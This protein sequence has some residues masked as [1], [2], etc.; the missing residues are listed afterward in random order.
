MAS[1]N[2]LIWIWT[3]LAVV[4]LLVLLRMPAPYG[5]LK[6]GKW[7]PEINNN[8]SWFLMEGAALIFFL[9]AFFQSLS[10]APLLEAAAKSTTQGSAD[11]DAVWLVLTNAIQ[12]KSLWDF[13]LPN[14]D[15]QLLDWIKNG[16]VALL[17]AVLYV[18]HYTYRT[19]IFPLRIRTK[20]KRVPVMITILGAQFNF[21][22]G[23]LNGFFLGASSAGA[24]TAIGAS[25]FPT[26]TNESASFSLASQ[27]P[28]EQ[29]LPS[30]GIAVFV[31]GFF[32]HFISD[33][34]LIALRTR[35][36][37]T[38]DTFTFRCRSCC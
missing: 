19:F 36:E 5:R 23:T 1:L 4:T 26:P 16:S 31:I 37:K 27:I 14:P 29:I 10:Q 25:S 2:F 9:S 3:G 32:I 13:H 21:I 17:A 7:G 33:H 20:K 34:K 38:H 28:F 6:T 24:S 18:F 35:K 15:F 11:S 22:N 30:L 12:L 8:L